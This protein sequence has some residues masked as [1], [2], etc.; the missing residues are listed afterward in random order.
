MRVH[1]FILIVAAA[2]SR[3]QAGGGDDDGGGNNTK[4]G[5]GGG[6]GGGD[7]GGGGGSDGGGGGVCA[8]GLGPWTGN[9]NVAP[10][11]SPPCALAPADVPQF[12][13]IGF[14][15]NAYS[16]LAGT[17]GTGGMTWATDMARTRTNS[18][19]PRR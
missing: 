11:Q 16:G 10:S 15:D 18:G 19:V 6:G 3:G 4:D 12:V 2:C 8:T 17:N 14:D 9:D 7:G 5:G 1:L 13:T